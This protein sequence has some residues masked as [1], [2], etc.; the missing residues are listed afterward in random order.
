LSSVIQAIWRE[1]ARIFPI[2]GPIL[3]SAGHPATE[4]GNVEQGLKN[5]RP[6]RFSYKSSAAVGREPIF[7]SRP[8]MHLR[9]CELGFCITLPAGRVF[10]WLNSG[11][12]CRFLGRSPSGPV[13]TVCIFA[14]R[15]CIFQKYPNWRVTEFPGSLRRAFP[16]RGRCYAFG[17]PLLCKEKD[18]KNRGDSRSAGK[19][20]GPVTCALLRQLFRKALPDRT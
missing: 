19:P 20:P 9:S 11:D 18:G 14:T 16:P 8:V 17:R 6:G 5:R 15:C 3:I 2:H 12:S 1:H 4:R 10:G 13:A 7:A